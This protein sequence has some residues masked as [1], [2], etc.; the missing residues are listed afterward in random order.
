VVERD[1]PGTRRILLL[2]GVFLIPGIFVVAVF[3]HAMN[4]VLAG[5]LGQLGIALPMLLLLLALL[6]AFGRQL[7]R[8]ESPR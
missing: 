1:E 7:R 5:D 6:V 3:W 2:L 8:L 4:Q